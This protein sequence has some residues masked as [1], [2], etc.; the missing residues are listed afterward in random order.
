VSPDVSR[1]RDPVAL[2]LG[3]NVGDRATFL[4]LARAYLG[5]DR[6]VRILKSSSVY[7][8]E[9]V[10]CPPQRWFLNQV[11]W[12]DTELPPAL[13]LSHCKRVETV[14]GRRRTTWHGPRTLDVDVLFVGSLVVRTPL[15]TLPHPAI[16]QRR[17]IL[18]PLVELG[19]PWV[20]PV[21]GADAG[22]LLQRCRDRSRVVLVVPE[23][24]V[25]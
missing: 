17:S 24:S 7:E 19:L 13:L 22:T 1:R 11:L 6:L 2:S 10:E 16:P 12:V 15:L 23:I 14:L 8:T 21:L 4:S 5:A 9:P 20:H 18:T 3:S 25:A